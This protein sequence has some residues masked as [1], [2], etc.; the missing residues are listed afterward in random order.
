MFSMPVTA[1]KAYDLMSIQLGTALPT[2]VSVNAANGEITLPQGIWIL[3]GSCRVQAGGGSSGDANSRAYAT[4]GIRHGTN[5][6]HVAPWSYARW[7]IDAGRTLPGSG[8]ST[9]TTM[10]SSLR[11][12]WQ[13]MPISVAGAVVVGQN[14]PTISLRTIW[15]FQRGTGTFTILNAHLHAVKIER[16]LSADLLALINGLNALDTI[17]DS[18]GLLTFDDDGIYKSTFGD[19]PSGSSEPTE[20]QIAAILNAATT[21]TAPQATSYV[22]LINSAGNLRKTLIDN[23]V[24]NGTIS[25]AKI[26]NNAVVAGKIASGA[27]TNAKIG[28]GQVNARTIGQG[29]VGTAQIAPNAIIS[30]SIA[31]GT[32]VASDLNANVS[33]RLLPEAATDGSQLGFVPKRAMLDRYRY[34]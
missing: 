28:D 27:V 30:N 25:S 1:M 14:S 7:S 32:I 13:I 20:A 17:T 8:W 11:R 21:L 19:V 2:G 18:T 23:A 3:C 26:A 5:W 22:P 34:A 15:T 10:P 31:N 4:L 9:P 33:S 16:F 24:R 29:S 6:R 12:P